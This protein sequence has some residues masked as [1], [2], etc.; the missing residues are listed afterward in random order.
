MTSDK[1][2]L[3]LARHLSLVTV[4][5]MYL[6]YSVLLSVG[7][8][9]LLPRFLLDWLRHGKYVASV[10]ERFGQNLQVDA[11]GRSIIWVHCVSVGETQAARPLVRAL[12][13][14]YPAYAIVV[15]TTT[16]TGQAVARDVFR[17]SA[18][19][20]IYFP[21]DWAW[22]VR[23]AL[24]RVNPSIVLLMETE[25][26]PRFLHECRTR[27]VPV[28]LV[29]GR[30][31]ERSL[32][33]YKRL[34]RLLHRVVNDFALAIMQTD[35]D[36]ERIAALGLDPRR[37]RVSGNIKFDANIET[38]E[39]SLTDELK[40]RFGFNDKRPLIIAA[41]THAPE[42][43]I[44]LQAFTQLHAEMGNTRSHPLPRL[45][46]APRHPERFSEVASLLK[47]SGFGWVRRS[48]APSAS[49]AACAV[50]LL[51]TIGELQVV[52]PLASLVF[53]GG[54]IAPVGG[55]NVLEPAA[56][57]KCVITGAHTS[58]FASI[59][60]SLL[61]QNALVQLPAGSDAAVSLELTR[62]FQELI[63]DMDKRRLIGERARAVMEQSRGATAR[64][65]EL[66]APLFDELSPQRSP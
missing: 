65:I 36:G 43:R 34:G 17:D 23:Q 44:V 10:R 63:V 5:F 55:H 3:I 53:I 37:L 25:L 1:I 61:E 60:K 18:A 51:D 4:H 62:V 50:V 56:A 26:W 32:R 2:K 14:R 15:S 28:V 7:I 29:N 33:G 47:S 64:T 38:K 30:I 57:A 49:D 31:S 46:I 39:Q 11:C 24:D 58:N 13:E 54:S 16:L 19:A 20:V 66:L 59:V 8:I 41:S 6:L 12:I 35:R 42:E 21:F 45:L 9:L 22:T 40:E 27:R 48:S 52:F